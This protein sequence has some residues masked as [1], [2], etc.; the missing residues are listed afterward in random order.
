MINFYTQ[1][2]VNETFDQ[3]VLLEMFFAWMN[4]TKIN[5]M[6]TLNYQ[7]EVSY[8]C[9]E[10]KKKLRIED[11]KENKMGLGESGEK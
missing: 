1:V 3:E 11:F 5:K 8:I 10:E 2:N 6:D 7:N 4:A 9:E